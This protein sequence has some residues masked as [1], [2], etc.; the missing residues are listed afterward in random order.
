MSNIFTWVVRVL[1]LLLLVLSLGVMFNEN[2]A[3]YMRTLFGLSEKSGVL[4][5]LAF[6]GGGC[7]IILQIMIANRRARAMENTAAAQA[8]ATKQQAN[9]NQNTEDGQRQE[10]LKNAIEHLGHKSVSV[11]LGG[12]YELFHLAQ[13]TQEFRQSAFSRLVQN[14]QELLHFGSRPLN[15]QARITVLAIPVLTA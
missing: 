3:L 4:E 2:I 12:A 8:H 1:F 15:T 7:L 13:D 9:A 14:T 11:R 6:A 5:Y 10:R